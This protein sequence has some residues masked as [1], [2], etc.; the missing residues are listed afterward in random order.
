MV[1][2]I[3]EFMVIEIY[4]AMY[5]QI[6]ITLNFDDFNEITRSIGIS[7]VLTV[8]AKTKLKRNF[9]AVVKNI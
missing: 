4:C 2:Y 1:I 8:L 3:I 6:V 5:L 7:K 9:L